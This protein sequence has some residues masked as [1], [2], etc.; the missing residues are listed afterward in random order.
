MAAALVNFKF[1][2]LIIRLGECIEMQK[3]LSLG[4]ESKWDANMF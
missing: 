1:T 2:Q 3:K 4:S